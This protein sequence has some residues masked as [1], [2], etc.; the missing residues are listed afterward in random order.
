MPRSYLTSGQ[1][2]ALGSN[3]MQ[4]AIFLYAEFSSGP[5]YLWTGTGSIAWG[6]NTWIGMGGIGDITPI[7]EGGDVQARGLS[8]NLSGFDSSLLSH[9]LTPNEFVLGKTVI[10]Y[11]GLFDGAGS[12]I[13]T[14]FVLWSGRIDQPHI[15]VDGATASI[16]IQCQDKIIDLNTPVDRRWTDADQ[17]LVHP[18]DKAFEFVN[19]IQN[20]TIYWG[21]TANNTNTP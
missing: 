20:M 1:I 9:L 21:R 4:P 15:H 19:T 14:P 8:L 12:L 3:Q 2:A 7:E 6:G 11:M 5:I 16:N 18:G 10:L 13:D 17:Q